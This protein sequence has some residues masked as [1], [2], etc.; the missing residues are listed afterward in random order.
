M[1]VFARCAAC[2]ADNQLGHEFCR[3]C[4][5]VLTD[6]K[7]IVQVAQGGQ[8]I[9]RSFGALVDA[10]REEVELLKAAPR[11]KRGRPKKQARDSDV[12]AK[13]KRPTTA[14]TLLEGVRT[15]Q[16]GC[17]RLRDVWN[18]YALRAL[19]AL[20]EP[21]FNDSL[22][23]IHVGPAL[24]DRPLVSIRPTDIEDFM[25]HLRQKRITG[26]W[27]NRK[28]KGQPLSMQRILHAVR[29]VRR[30]FNYAA[31]CDMWDGPNPV[32]RLR[33]P[34]FDNEIVRM[35]SKAQ[36]GQ[37]LKVLG[38]WPNRPAALAFK[39]CLLTGKRAGEVFGLEW[40]QVDL[41]RGFVRFNI[42]SIV[43]GAGQTLP[44]SQAVREILEDA[45]RYQAPGVSH[46][47]ATNQGKRIHYGAIWP[48]VRKRAGLPGD[49][50]VH[51]LRHAF[52]SELVSNGCDLFL[53]QKLLGHKSP[54]M[55][56]RYAHMADDAL[57]RGLAMAEAAFLGTK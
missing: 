48:R 57:R 42:K 53:V 43:R 8:N 24:G 2:R 21:R 16:A 27:N 19:P 34:K 56:M 18:R 31:Q 7:Y 22:W 10:Y 11:V 30:L 32:S 46:V 36:A 40:S 45:L 4:G 41:D 13:S 5:A 51:D 25:D 38:D 12:G 17:P 55:T 29:L 50:R 33:L 1:S 49:F 9:R 23:R 52:A 28:K 6:C 35:L 37:L 54:A 15:Q 3:K 44:I 26:A 47:F 39:M 14:P 20:K